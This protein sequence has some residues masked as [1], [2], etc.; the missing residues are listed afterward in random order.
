MGLTGKGRA[1]PSAR[2]FLLPFARAGGRMRRP[3]NPLFANLP[4]SI[5]EHMSGLARDLGAI[6]LGQGFPNFDGPQFVKQAGIDAIN[7]GH[8]QYARMYGIPA[9][10]EAIA[11]RWLEDT[12]AAADPSSEVTVRSRY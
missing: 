10:N 6:N 12:G 9:L 3:M 4:T 1:P 2:P 5:F 8:G 11:A 7:A